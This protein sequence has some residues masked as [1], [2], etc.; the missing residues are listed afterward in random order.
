M[1][2][3]DCIASAISNSTGL[4]NTYNMGVGMS[5]IVSA[6]TA[7]DAVSALKAEGVEAYGIGEIV[8]GEERICLC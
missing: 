2:F 1:I 4:F 3:T 7:D 8:P 6:D 5:L